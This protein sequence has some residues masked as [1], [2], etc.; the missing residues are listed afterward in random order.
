[1]NSFVMCL[2]EQLRES[3][4]RV[5]ELSPPVVQSE[6]DVIPINLILD[7]LQVS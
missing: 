6:F 4:V 1:M 5:I 3:K 7:P 2:R